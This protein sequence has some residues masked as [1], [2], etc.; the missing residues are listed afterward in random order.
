MY[1]TLPRTAGARFKHLDPSGDGILTGP[2]IEGLVH[3]VT[4]RALA[5]RIC[6]SGLDAG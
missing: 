1:M 3:E 2:E 6:T 5:A 4:R